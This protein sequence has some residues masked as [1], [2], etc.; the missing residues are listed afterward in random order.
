MHP[1]T[2][3]LM[4]QNWMRVTFLHWRYA[5]AEVQRLLPRQLQVEMFDGSAWVGLV[6]FEIL[7]LRLAGT[8]AIPWL[9]FFRETNVRTYVT[10]PDGRPGVWF[11]SLDAA[12]LLAVLG[13][14]WSYGLPYRWARMSLEED[15][16]IVRYRSARY[17]G[18]GSVDVSVRPGELL[19]QT[20]LEEF[21]TA[22]FGLFSLHRKRLRY[23]PVEHAPW[24]LYRAELL[25]L[26]EDLIEAAGLAAPQ[27][28]PAVHFSPG[29]KVRVGAL[30]S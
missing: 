16:G 21:L 26:R 6:P 25:N 22:R 1:V 12:R 14:R 19:E 23:G 3:P 4:Y 30:A 13:A 15:A 11:F 27:G 20:A 28:E 18:T 7:E 2:R 8:P 17:R 5:A 10:D 9:G 29:V 24:P